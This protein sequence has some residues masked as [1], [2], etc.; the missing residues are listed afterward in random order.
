MDRLRNH[1]AITDVESSLIFLCWLLTQDLH[2]E[3]DGRISDRLCLF[4]SAFVDQHVPTVRQ[5][6]GD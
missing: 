6:A 4:D 3:H 5:D 2:N 1:T